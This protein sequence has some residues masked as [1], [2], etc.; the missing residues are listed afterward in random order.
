LKD[1]VRRTVANLDNSYPVGLQGSVVFISDDGWIE[2]VWD[3]HTFREAYC[4]KSAA[5][6]FEPVTEPPRQQVDWSGLAAANT[7]QP[8]LAQL[9]RQVDFDRAQQERMMEAYANQ[10]AAQQ[11]GLGGQQGQPA[12]AA[13]P[14]TLEFYR[15]RCSTFMETNLQMADRLGVLEAELKEERARCRQLER[16]LVGARGQRR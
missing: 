10:Q 8:A 7:Y 9:Q 16:E 3:G 5:P 12:P 15:S 6:V 14:L 11:R 4:L 13:D 1:R 2:I